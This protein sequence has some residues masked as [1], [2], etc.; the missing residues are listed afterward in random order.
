[1]SQAAGSAKAQ[2][3]FMAMVDP[4]GAASVLAFA[5]LQAVEAALPEYRSSALGRLG[6]TEEAEAEARR[7]TRPSGDGA[8]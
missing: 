2:G 4:A 3:E 7:A 5:V 1:M 8:A 6:R